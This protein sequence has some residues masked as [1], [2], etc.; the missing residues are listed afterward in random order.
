[1]RVEEYIEQTGRLLRSC[2][3]RVQVIMMPAEA[4]AIMAIAQKLARAPEIEPLAQALLGRLEREIARQLDLQAP[5]LGRLVA[6]GRDPRND[7][8]GPGGEVIV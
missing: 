4:Y 7:G 8:V 6:A 1:V 5:G 2:G 3:G